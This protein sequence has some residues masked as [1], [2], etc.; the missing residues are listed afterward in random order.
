MVYDCGGDL[1][2]LKETALKCLRSAPM[3]ADL[4]EHSLWNQVCVS[5]GGFVNLLV[6]DS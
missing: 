2:E 6:S 3:L 4:S 1:A 5:R